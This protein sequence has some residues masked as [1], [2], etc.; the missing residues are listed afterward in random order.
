[1]LGFFVCLAL[2][3]VVQEWVRP[4]L[5]DSGLLPLLATAPSFLYALAGVLGVAS[6]VGWPHVWR[7][8]AAPGPL[9]YE[10]MQP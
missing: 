6:V 8:R 9:A 2:T 5:R 1:M 10:L 7:W 3:V 4:A